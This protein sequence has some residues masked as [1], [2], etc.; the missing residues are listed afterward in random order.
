[1]KYVARFT[2]IMLMGASLIFIVRLVN[3]SAR[4]QQ[5]DRIVVRAPWPVEPVRIVAAKTK[6]KESVEIGKAFDE[7]DDWLDGFTV[8]VANKY[9]KAVTALTLEMTFR[10]EPGDTR[11]PFN[12]SLH[13]GPS[14]NI[15]EYL[16][17]DPNKVIKVGKTADIHISPED[18]KSLKRYLEQTGYPGSIKRVE[19]TIREV[20]F[21]DGSMLDAGTFYLQDPAYPDDPTKKI[22]VR[23]PPGARNQKIRS[24]PHRETVSNSFSFLKASLTSP[25]PMLVSLTLPNRMQSEDCKP[26]DTPIRQKCGISD[27]CSLSHDRL[28]PFGIGAW[29]LEFQLKNCQM[30]QSTGGWVDC[31]SFVEDVERFVQCEIPC[32]QMWGVLSAD[33]RLLRRADL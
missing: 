25:N 23:E 4:S 14:P 18:Y 16:N 22:P 13:F 26:K 24:P 3:S 9:D 33:P 27:N 5:K 28:A 7:D 32:V 30:L 11:P 20:G 8:T 2:V 15:R 1:M 31:Q 10:R 17:R 29:T 19:L 12:Y 21:E 6:N